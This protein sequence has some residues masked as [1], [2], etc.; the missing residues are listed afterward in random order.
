MPSRS[1][2]DMPATVTAFVL[3]VV[4]IGASVPF[5]KSKGPD[6]FAISWSEES[7]GKASAP[8]APTAGT[9]AMAMVTVMGRYP[10]NATITFAPCVDPAQPPLQQPA[11]ITWSLTKD[12]QPVAGA[13]DQTAT[14]A[15]KG[16]FTVKLGP[17]PDIGSATGSNATVAGH[18]AETAGAP[19]NTTYMLTFKWTR[20]AGATGPL[21]LPPPTFGTTGTLEVKV[22]HAT[23]NAPGQGATR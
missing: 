14:C 7:F 6:S 21:P 5:L 10:S 23:A 13:K 22:W 19:A 9:D 18:T 17:H 16:P 3:G 4:L 11:T 15:N 12:G 1:E 8:N 20:P 2:M